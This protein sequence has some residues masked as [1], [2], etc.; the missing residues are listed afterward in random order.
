ML[1]ILWVVLSSGQ[2]MFCVTED[3]TSCRSHDLLRYVETLYN[4]FSDGMRQ[5]A[6]PLNNLFDPICLSY[7]YYNLN[8]LKCVIHFGIFWLKLI[9]NMYQTLPLIMLFDTIYKK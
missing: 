3:V 2:L 9:E 7:C 8:Y 6:T 1:Y 4:L 5:E